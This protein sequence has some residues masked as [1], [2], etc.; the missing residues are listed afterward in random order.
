MISLVDIE[1]ENAVD[2]LMEQIYRRIINEFIGEEFIVSW[3][4]KKDR[5]IRSREDIAKALATRWSDLYTNTL[6]CTER[7]RKFGWSWNLW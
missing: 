5:T 3:R 2:F 1:L 6:N 7:I 4:K